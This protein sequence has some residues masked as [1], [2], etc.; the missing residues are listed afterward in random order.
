MAINPITGKTNTVVPTT[1][2]AKKEKPENRLETNTRQA[3]DKIDIT[4]VAQEIKRAFESA[5]STPVIDNNK[6]EAVKAALQSGNYQINADSIA[7]KMIQFDR[8]FDS[9]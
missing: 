7:E 9:T 1:S 6:I 5:P 8:P 3:S 4:A 2:Q